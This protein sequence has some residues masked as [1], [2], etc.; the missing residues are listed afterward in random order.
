MEL[1][2]ERELFK[3]LLWLLNFDL[4]LVFYDCIKVGRDTYLFCLF[5][6]RSFT[7]TDIL[8]AGGICHDLVVEGDHTS[9]IFA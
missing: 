3:S 1:Y 8:I 2:F 6:Y 7:Y 9:F 5:C 4:C